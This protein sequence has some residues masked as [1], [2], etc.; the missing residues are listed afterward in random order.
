L[1]G[2]ILNS[3][4]NPPDEVVD[5]VKIH[6]PE[7]FDSVQ[8]FLNATLKSLKLPVTTTRTKASH[9]DLRLLSQKVLWEDVR[10]SMQEIRINGHQWVEIQHM[11][12]RVKSLK[13]CAYYA[14]IEIHQIEG[15]FCLD[16]D[17]VM[18]MSDP[19]TSRVFCL[20]YNDILPKGFSGK[21][22][23]R[24]TKESYTIFD[25][26]F[27]TLVNQIYKDIAS[28]EACCMALMFKY[29]DGLDAATEYYTWLVGDLKS[30]GSELALSMLY[31]L[32]QHSL[33]IQQLAELHGLYR[34]WGHPTV[35]E[36]LG[37]EKVRSIG[38]NRPI[39]DMNMCLRAVG[40]LKRQFVASFL[41]RHGRW[42]KLQPNEGLKGRPLHKLLTSQS[43]VLNL[44]SPEYKLEDWGQVRFGQ[45]FTFDYHLDYTELQEDKSTLLSKG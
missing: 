5:W 34:H 31:Y 13:V 2:I 41:S 39:P 35:N 3:A 33:S 43:R 44:Y 21:I 23:S 22:E 7:C 24:I 38:K 45:E 32:E 27:E 4:I 16:Y 36:A 17:Q 40:C 42:P 8:R 6:Y 29:H 25:K 9:T 10:I 18:M 15:I 1:Y 11:P 14:I 20:I 30:T 26:G 37:C 19:I 28:W 12:H